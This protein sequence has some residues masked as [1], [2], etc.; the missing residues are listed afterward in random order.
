MVKEL[1]VLVTIPSDAVIV[2][3]P[4]TSKI[5][6]EK[7]ATPEE[8]VVALTVLDASKPPGPLLI[9]KVTVSPDTGAF[10]APRTVTEAPSA[11]PALTLVG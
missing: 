1:E 11:L 2:Y 8:F 7:V 5:K 9:D 10:E 4:A 6:F 3:E